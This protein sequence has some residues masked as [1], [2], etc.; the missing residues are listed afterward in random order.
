MTYLNNFAEVQC[1][2]EALAVEAIAI[3][4]AQIDCAI[5][6]SGL[7]PDQN[8]QWL[9]YLNALALFVFEQWLDERAEEL[10]I[11]TD[12]CSIL[13]PQYANAI[14]AVCNLRVGE[15]NLCLIA[16]G[17][18]MDE[19]VIVPR[20]AI[21]LPEFA[22]H[23]YVWV[24][25]QEEC[26]LAIIRGFV[27]RDCL[28]QYCL[29][30]NLQPDL[31]WTYSLPIAWFDS[32]PNRLLLYL[33][34]LEASAIALPIVPSD[35]IATLSR[36][37]A[38]LATLLPQLQT[39]ETALSQVLNWQ[40]GVAVLTSPE[41]LKWVYQ[42]QISED[43][44]EVINTNYLSDL[45]TLLTQQALNVAH[46]LQDQMDDLAQGLSWVLMP[47]FVPVTVMRSARTLEEG[48]PTEELQ[49]IIQQLTNTG[50]EIPTTARG[51]Y[52][53]LII[54]DSAVRLYALTWPF[55]SPENTTEW[56]LVLVIGPQPGRNLPPGIRLRVS[57]QSGILVQR[58]H[59][60]NSLDP[61]LYVVIAGRWDEKFLATITLANGTTL[62]LPPFAFRP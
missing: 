4:S 50:I 29:E 33:R 8:K 17:S 31:D 18:A 22:A 37:V 3:E 26:E 55:L 6:I 43:K 20:A 49:G 11:I 14:E 28:M 12:N 58:R 32:D 38:E 44:N 13:Q 60:P 1:E 7:V 45:L 48:L 23:F 47:A 30:T 19:S 52:Q 62:T 21:D 46:W 61:Y 5:Q 59:N 25:V 41:L 34:C 35:R 54:A 39:A 40:Q 56:T 24:E 57:D 27:R 9:T 42:L 51:A 15:F 2:F 16:T 36:I 10:S 53:E